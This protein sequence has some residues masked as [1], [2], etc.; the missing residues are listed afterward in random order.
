MQL[1]EP[2]SG[3]LQCV[4][5]G[6]QGRFVYRFTN[7]DRNASFRGSI[8]VA[9]KNR[10]RMPGVSG[11]DITTAGGGAIAISDP[12][13]G[14]DFPVAFR[15][16]LDVYGCVPLPANPQATVS[17]EA[18]REISLKP[19]ESK[20]VEIFMRAWGMC[21]SGSCSEATVVLIGDY[22]DQTDGFACASF[23]MGVDSTKAPVYDWPDSCNVLA[24]NPNPTA[25]QVA[26]EYFPGHPVALNVI[27]SNLQV[28]VNGSPSSISGFP[29]NDRL[30]QDTA[31]YQIQFFNP[32][33]LF[34]PGDQIQLDYDLTLMQLGSGYTQELTSVVPFSPTGY[35]TLGPSFMINDHIDRAN[36]KQADGWLTLMGQI[37]GRFSELNGVERIYPAHFSDVSITPTQSGPDGSQVQ[38]HVT[39]VTVAPDTFEPDSNIVL[40]EVYYDLRGCGQPLV[41][42]T[43]PAEIIDAILGRSE[44]PAPPS[45]ALNFNGDSRVDAADYVYW[46]QNFGTPVGGN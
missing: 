13:D 4:S 43:E 24:V 18:T 45:S 37:S 31:R 7:N 40:L 23:A 3:E 21:A 27:P 30:D 44:M 34:E 19:G 5:P 38:L 10:S 46:Q 1:V 28:Q 9:S 6:G 8:R 14:D 11:G 42:F 29:F 16:G 41:E 20:D 25:I 39:L 22:S 26:G 17:P 36:P 12:G 32:S 2:A 35:E 33:G 15:E